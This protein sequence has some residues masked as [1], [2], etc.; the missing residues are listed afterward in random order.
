MILSIIIPCYNEARN[1]PLLL[2]AF[3]QVNF[4]QQIEVILVENGSSDESANLLKSL[5]PSYPFLKTIYLSQ[6]EGYGGGIIR[7]L[8]EAKG[9][10]IAWTHADLQIQPAD[11][12]NVLKLLKEKNFSKNIFIKG[13]RQGRSYFDQFFTISMAIFESLLLRQWLWDIN[14]QPNVFHRS[15]LSN[16]LI[17]P[18]DFSFD[19]YFYVKAKKKGLEICRF[20]VTFAPRKYGISSWNTGFKGKW[21]FIKRTFALSLILKKEYL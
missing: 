3:S 14:S 11:F 1:L 2:D 18:S 5:S 19:L 15:F 10:F 21:K 13:T 17:P 4:S 8:S 6:N 20:P 12:L 9:N 16:L 7:G